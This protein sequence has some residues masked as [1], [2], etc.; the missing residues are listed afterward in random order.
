MVDAG[1]IRSELGITVPAASTSGTYTPLASALSGLTFLT[2]GYGARVSIT[3]ITPATASGYSSLMAQLKK[4]AIVSTVRGIGSAAFSGTGPSTSSTLANGETATT[5][6]VAENLWVYVAG[7]SIFELS[8]RKGNLT[9]EK[10][11]AKSML[12]LV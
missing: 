1:L 2:C 9:R 6:M 4:A 12:P 11:L 10:A 7:K 8:V 5:T 3:F